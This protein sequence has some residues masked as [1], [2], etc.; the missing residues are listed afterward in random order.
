MYTCMIEICTK[1]VSFRI[2]LIEFAEIWY[3]NGR[4]K[5]RLVRRPCWCVLISNA[6]CR[7]FDPRHVSSLQPRPVRMGT[8]NSMPCVKRVPRFLQVKNP[9]NNSSRCPYPKYLHF[10]VAVIISPT[11]LPDDLFHKTYILYLL[12][13]WSRPEHA[14]NIWHWT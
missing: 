7:G 10:L 2:Y 1:W 9:C 11:F 5:T 8:L 3:I 12:L 4:E 13:T 14:W 6:R